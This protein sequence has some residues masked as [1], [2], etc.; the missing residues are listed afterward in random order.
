MLQYLYA[1][2]VFDQMFDV[3]KFTSQSWAHKLRDWP[4]IGALSAQTALVGSDIFNLRLSSDIHILNSIIFNQ[5]AFLGKK[6]PHSVHR[7]LG[8]RFRR[9]V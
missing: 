8:E 7:K 9:H 4:R 3:D 2:R 5:A 1:M 6:R